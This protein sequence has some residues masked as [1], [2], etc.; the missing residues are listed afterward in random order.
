MTFRYST[1]FLL[2]G[3]LASCDRD[4]DSEANAYVATPEP[5]VAAAVAEQP[6]R[7][8]PAARHGGR[9]VVI[10]EHAVEVVTRNDG[11]VRAYV[12]AMD[13][14][15]LPSSGLALAVGV[16]GDDGTDHQVALSRSG[17]QDFYLGSLVDV[18]PV[19]GPLAVTLWIGGTPHEARTTLEVVVA[20]PTPPP[21]PPAVRIE[22]GIPPGHLPPPEYRGDRFD[23]PP[24]H[25]PPPEYRGGRLDVPPGHLPPPEYR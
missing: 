17:D 16:R 22:I 20:A 13:G 8:P 14:S 21:P 9:V 2:C 19:P 18:R 12:M 1:V 15:P 6:V 23:V 10:E 24:G 5:L 25:L 11:Q 7:A 3:V 4:S